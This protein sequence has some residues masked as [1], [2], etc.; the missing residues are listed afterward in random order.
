MR[1]GARRPL[2]PK[3]PLRSM[4]RPKGRRARVSGAHSRI[5][6]GHRERAMRPVELVHAAMSAAHAG[7]SAAQV[8]TAT[9]RAAKPPAAGN[10]SAVPR[11]PGAP[12][13]A[14]AA[15]TVNSLSGAGVWFPDTAHVLDP[16]LVARAFATASV[17]SGASLLRAEVLQVCPRGDRIE[18][19]TDSR[20]ITARTVVICAG[21][22]SAP[23]LAPFGSH[24]PLEAERGY[25]V[26]ISNHTPLVDA[27]ILYA[28]HSVVITPMA[29]RLRASSYLEFTGLSTPADPRKP[30]QLRTQLRQ[31]GVPMRR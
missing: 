14:S 24:A 1:G 17:Q 15:A 28:E 11:A 21:A 2:T 27:P 25:H 26:E 18:I 3:R 4:A 10:A 16:A 22:W 9:A 30:T 19:V 13:L 23:L 12:V 8:V 29:S 6:P 31:L 7:T 5:K 20:A